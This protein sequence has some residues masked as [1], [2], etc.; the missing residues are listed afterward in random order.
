MAN[1]KGIWCITYSDY[2]TEFVK[3][4]TVWQ[5]IDSCKLKQDTDNIVNIIRIDFAG[6]WEEE[7]SMTD[8][9]REY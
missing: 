7:D 2:T 1:S 3:A 4:Y 9:S 8:V 6:G 5:I